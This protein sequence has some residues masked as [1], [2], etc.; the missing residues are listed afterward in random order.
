MFNSLQ[1][2]RVRGVSFHDHTSFA[3]AVVQRALFP[4]ECNHQKSDAG[5]DDAHPHRKVAAER[6]AARNGGP[7]GLNDLQI[8]RDLAGTGSARTNKVNLV[9]TA[10]R[11]DEWRPAE[12][13]QDRN[14][15]PQQRQDHPQNNYVDRTCRAAN[16]K[17]C[18]VDSPCNG[19]RRPDHSRDRSGLVLNR[20]QRCLNV[21][22][23]LPS[24][25]RPFPQAKPN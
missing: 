13:R 21:T 1:T 24:I 15:E 17:S 25:F 14:Q 8:E 22:H 6:Q 16:P 10:E 3:N 9:N 7:V 20:H 11:E 19:L 2:D 5:G 18:V 4:V 23:R 12:Q